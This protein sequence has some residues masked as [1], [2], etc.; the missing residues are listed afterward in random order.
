MTHSYCTLPPHRNGSN[1]LNRLEAI[2]FD[3]ATHR[4]SKPPDRIVPVHHAMQR[5][6][7]P[8]KVRIPFAPFLAEHFPVARVEARRAMPHL[9]GMISASAL[10]RQFQK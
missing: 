6:L 5:L 8:R 10:L 4:V 9:F 3:D 1:F 7:T 2:A